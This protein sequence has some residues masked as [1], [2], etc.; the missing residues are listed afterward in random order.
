M[1]LFIALEFAD[2][3]QERFSFCRDLVQK[4]AR[5]GTFVPDGNFHATL[6]FL[7]DVDESRVEGIKQTMDN[8]TLPT[9]QLTFDRLGYFDPK[10][11]GKIYWVGIRKDGRLE[12]IHKGLFRGLAEIGF[13][14]DKRPFS[15]HVTIGRRVEVEKTAERAI[16]G[17]FTP[18]YSVPRS[19]SLMLSERIEGRMVYTALH[20]RPFPKEDG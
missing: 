5:S 16:S 9:L 14:L 4:H 19:L 13:H 10:R 15:P 7:G 6:L 1:R 18:F 2:D 11:P 8:I 3:T 20:V 17:D 12:R